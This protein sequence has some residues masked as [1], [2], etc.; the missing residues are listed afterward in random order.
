MSDPAAPP[1]LR[2][3]VGTG[4][5]VLPG[6][7]GRRGV[8]EGLIRWIQRQEVV[9]FASHRSVMSMNPRFGLEPGI[10]FEQL[11]AEYADVISES[12]DEPVDLI[13]IS[14]GG[15]IALQLAADRPELIR[16]LVLVSSAHRLSDHGRV[17]QR[18]I[19]Q[20]LRQGKSRK[21]AALFLSNAGATRLSRAALAVAGYL[22]PRVVVG[23]DDTDLLA[24]L[25]AEDS[26]DIAPRL[27]AID[28]RTLVTGGGHDRFYTS[29]LFDAT[30]RML[31]QSTLTI[32][33]RGGHLGIA[34]NRRLARAVLE[35]LSSD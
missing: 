28:I 35:F 19:A 15:T 24:L 6:L 26:F 8:P 3:G 21:A 4:L 32:Y 17:V 34:G 29:A 14:T 22:V 13:G 1:T 7:A 33:P 5:V 16:R 25:D 27:G 18:E 10:S 11:A 9:E 20:L 31:P 2:V 30:S 12:F 23:R